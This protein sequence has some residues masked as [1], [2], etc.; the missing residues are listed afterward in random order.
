MPSPKPAV[1]IRREFEATPQV[2]SQQLR[3]CIIGPACQLVRFA[4]AQEKANG[5]IAKQASLAT[6]TFASSAN[7]GDAPRNLLAADANYVVPSLVEGSM[8]DPDS[9]KVFV[10]DAL[11]TY[12]DF[13][14]PDDVGKDFR[15]DN[16]SA[17]VANSVV[18]SNKAWVGSSRPAALPQDVVVGDTIQLY[19][20]SGNNSTLIHTS[21]VA[22]FRSE[23]VSG[24]IGNPALTERASTSAGLSASTLTL[25]GII[26]TFNAASAFSTE[27]HMA[28]D[29]RK[30]IASALQQYNIRILGYKSNNLIVEISTAYGGL[31]SFNVEATIVTDGVDT[32]TL[33]NGI[34]VKAALVQGGTV[35]TGAT[36]SFSYTIAHTPYTYNS[37]PGPLRVTVSG[38]I[39]NTL[40]QDT[41]YYVVCLRGGS[42]KSSEGVL[43][44]ISSNNGASAPATFTIRELGTG[45]SGV[46][47]GPHGIRIDFG[48][49]ANNTF[50]AGF[51]V[52]DVLV[53]PVSA[54]SAGTVYS[55]VLAEPYIATSAVT[56]VRLS[57]R[58]TVEIT[59]F[60]FDGVTTNWNITN[61]NDS[62]LM[63]L[64]LSKQLLV[65]DFVVNS[66]NTNLYVTAGSIYVQYRSILNLPRTIGSVRTLSD[67]T[68]QLG[69]IDPDNPLAYAVFKAF[70]NANGATV[71]FIPILSETLNGVRGF[72]DALD[73]AKGNRNCYSLVPLTTSSEIWNACVAHIQDE[74]APEAGRFRI[75]WIAPEV[76]RHYK[77]QDSPI[78]DPNVLLRA[79]SSPIAGREGQYMLNVEAGLD[80]RFTETVRVGDW[81]R[82]KFGSNITT[83]ELTFQEFKVV[84]II[85]NLTLIVSAATNPQI[86]SQTIEVY[87]DLTPAEAAAIYVQVAG[88]FSS[89]RVFAVVPNRGVNGLRVNGRPVKNYYV[90]A[91]FAGLRSGSR[92]HQPLSNVELR[93]F[94]G[95]NPTVPAFNEADLDTL[96]D[97]GIWVVV[98]SDE[99][100]IYAERQL[101]TSTLDNFR[102][103]Q[104]VTCNIDSISFSI[105]DGLKNF[106]GRVNINDTNLGVVRANLDAIL[107]SFTNAISSPTI[108]PQLNDYTIED[109]FIPATANDTVKA[110]VSVSVPLP[111]NII[112]IT[113][114]V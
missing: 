36:G 9:V 43:F 1:I 101:S 39:D 106:V 95:N 82:S 54:V 32:Y 65:K 64:S 87:R 53:I 5:F 110:R 93:G 99:G 73:L 105:G 33:P 3:A 76:D 37:T 104:S 74:S 75:L 16:T 6:E 8:I 107:R 22:G 103:E 14:D 67:I 17:P 21:K 68:S 59:K 96:R 84:N 31:G 41:I 97:G 4:N 23:E 40:T 7:A 38:T 30:A 63:R 26:F 51:F 10:E 20:T 56:R 100:Q 27:E 77:I 49:L 92:P 112:D 79:T 108:G 109:V 72:A 61:S 19:S 83:G 2:V 114:V 66:G 85:D 12:A 25:G 44:S 86:I 58:K 55:L 15:P 60:K 42:V 24:G 113:I 102:K 98:N 28:Y 47:N 88:G 78:G 62:S 70:T 11:L 45:V 13:V 50:A 35:G 69:T 18:L 91:A 71:H 57:K 46:Y 89:E 80:S 48:A 81:I 94:D 29:P 111:M 52:G 90:A 34:T